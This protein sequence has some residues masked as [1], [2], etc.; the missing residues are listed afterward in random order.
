[1][2]LICDFFARL[3]RVSPL[4][5]HCDF[6]KNPKAPLFLEFPFR[7]LV[8][9]TKIF[10]RLR[11]RRGVLILM[12][13]VRGV[14]RFD[15]F[16]HQNMQKKNH[17]FWN[18]EIPDHPLASDLGPHGVHGTPW[19]PKDPLQERM[20]FSSLRRATCANLHPGSCLRLGS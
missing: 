20:K 8:Q 3:R 6:E 5:I 15:H 13:F 2:V 4:Q 16:G 9:K 11:R 10:R 14:L 12:N 19:A 1:M 18:K 17:I 7:K